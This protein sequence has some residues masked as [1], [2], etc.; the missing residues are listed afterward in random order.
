L[1][2]AILA[3]LA[4]AG[5]ALFYRSRV[6]RL[7]RDLAAQNEAVL[8][9][10]DVLA[11]SIIEDCRAQPSASARAIIDAAVRRVRKD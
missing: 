7:G 8:V 11:E 6:R 10:A 2:L 9:L 4:C 1:I 3:A 5:A